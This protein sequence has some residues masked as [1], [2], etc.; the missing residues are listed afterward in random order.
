MNRKRK[1]R[2]LARR[3]LTVALAAVMGLAVFD[4][5]A[6]NITVFNCNDS[7]AIDAGNNV[8]A[9]PLLTDQRLAGYSR[10]SGSAADIGAY[11]LQQS[12]IVFTSNLEGCP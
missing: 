2:P 7:G 1:S 10:I 3:K 12:D 8:F 9:F 6:A 11:E 5:A 4:A